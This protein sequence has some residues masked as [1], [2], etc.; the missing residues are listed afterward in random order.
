MSGYVLVPSTNS[1]GVY[2]KPQVLR[3]LFAVGLL[4]SAAG[5]ESDDPGQTCTLIGCV[6]GFEIN[7]EKASAWAAGDYTFDLDVD[8]KTNSCTVTLP[9]TSCNDG[10]K[11]TTE[12]TDLTIGL[13]GCALPAAQHKIS[14]LTF[15]NTAPKTVA[16]TVKFGVD[17]IG[18]VSYTPTYTDSRPNG[19][20]C[21]PLCRQAPAQ[22]L[23]LK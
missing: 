6:G 23:S 14:G 3:A 22:T 15:F 9:F 19:P 16:V 12:L 10:L 8:G 21:E 11:C 20:N 13:S 1:G 5:C 4:F 17:E 7:L 2:S 18:S